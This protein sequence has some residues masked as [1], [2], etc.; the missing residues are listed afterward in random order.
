M[1]NDIDYSNLDLEIIKSI[2]EFP[3]GNF[4]NIFAGNVAKEAQKIDPKN[5]DK[6][7]HQRMQFLEKHGI[8]Y[9]RSRQWYLT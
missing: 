5:A 8:I 6:V 2:S 9:Q 3:G 7:T 4:Q 1:M